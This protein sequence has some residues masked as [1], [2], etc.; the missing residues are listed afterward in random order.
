MSFRSPEWLWLLAA[1][2]LVLPFLI[3]RERRRSYAA[4]RFVSERLRGIGNPLRVAR[5][6][7]LAVAAAAVSLALAGPY[8]G[9]TTVSVSTRE[10]NRVIAID[11]SHSMAAEDIGTSRLAAS[12]AI[13]KRIIERHGGRVALIAFEAGAE[14]ISP[15]T[16]DNDAVLALVETLQAGEV[17]RAGSDLGA[18]VIAALRLI[19]SDAGQKADIVLISDGEDQ[20]RRIDEAVNR[21]RARGVTVSGIVVGGAEGSTIVMR[22][23]PLRDE[24]GEVVVTYAR[25]DVVQR[26][27]RG[28]GGTSLENPF[29]EHALDPLLARTAAAA[30]RTSD[31]RV[32][33][34]R[35]QWPL[36]LAFAAF[37]CA[38]LLNRG[39]E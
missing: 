4:R 36:A 11:V 38:S 21:A 3:A 7:V 13:A 28:T 14:V 5:P 19:E 16:N 25:A 24:A 9:F 37:F 22:D 29:S 34:D 23:G 33:L 8:A 39:A 30:A 32:P 15:L 6:Y 10:A 12:K 20:G 35:F 1:V 27:A 18:A 31:V 26:L 2:P 17:G